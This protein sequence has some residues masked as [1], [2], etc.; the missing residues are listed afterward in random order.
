MDTLLPGPAHPL[1]EPSEIKGRDG[2]LVSGLTS[3]AREVAEVERLPDSHPGILGGPDL[4]HTKD[5]ESIF[6]D[7]VGRVMVHLGNR[8]LLRL[9]VL[10]CFVLKVGRSPSERQTRRRESQEVSMMDREKTM[11]NLVDMQR[12]VELRHRRD[13]ERQMLRVSEGKVR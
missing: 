5:H 9:L 11:R 6:Q 2:D 8:Q 13:R 7:K 12:K 10:G 4:M 3:E 1:V